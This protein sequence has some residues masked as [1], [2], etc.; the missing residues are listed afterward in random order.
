MNGADCRE[1]E[2]VQERHGCHRLIN[3]SSRHSMLDKGLGPISSS[4]LRFYV[5]R[6]RPYG[7]ERQ[8]TDRAAAGPFSHHISL[9][10]LPVGQ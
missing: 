5:G 1:E 8:Y 7:A 4:P 9:L 3:S 2:A 6:G 10:V